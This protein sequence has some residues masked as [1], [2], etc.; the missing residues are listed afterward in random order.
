MNATKSAYFFRGT[1]WSIQ[2]MLPVLPPHAVTV[3]LWSSIFLTD[4][5]GMPPF[6]LGYE[7]SA[8]PDGPADQ[9]ISMGILNGWD[10]RPPDRFIIGQWGTL[11]STVWDYTPTGGSYSD[12]AVRLYWFPITLCPGETRTVSTYYG[13]G[14]ELR[15]GR[16]SLIIEPT[17]IVNCTFTPNP[18]NALLLF[19]NSTGMPITDVTAEIILPDGLSLASGSR[20][21]SL[22][23]GALASGGVGTSNWN[24][25][26][27]YYPE[28][29]TIYFRVNSPDLDSASW[30]SY[31]LGLPELGLAPA[32]EVIAPTAGT[33]SACVDQNLDIRLRIENGLVRESLRF[34]VNSDT[35]WFPA[36][37]RLSIH[38]DTLTYSPSTPFVCGESYVWG[39]V[40][41]TDSAGCELIAPVWGAFLYDIEPPFAHDEYP[42]DGAILGTTDLEELSLSI[43]DLVRDVDPLSLSLDVNGIV[44]PHDHPALTWDGERLHFNFEIAGVPTEDGDTFCVS[45]LTASDLMPDYCE[46]NRMARPYNWCFRINI[47]DLW[48]PDTFAY[49]NDTVYIYMGVE[50]LTNMHVTDFD[51]R[52]RYFPSVM[53][54][55]GVHNIGVTMPWSPLLW[56]T[57]GGVLRVRGTGTELSGGGNL[58]KIIAVIRPEAAGGYSPLEF[59]SAVFNDGALSSQPVDGFMTILWSDFNFVGQLRFK[60]KSN[61]RQTILA[62]GASSS[63]TNLYDA[64]LDLSILP[65]V[66]SDVIAWFDLEDPLYP[67]I[68]RLR[69]D[70]RYYGDY[71]IIWTGHSEYGSE[72]ETTVVSWQPEYLPAGLFTLSYDSPLGLVTLNMHRV[73]TFSFTGSVDFTIRYDHPEIVRQ[74]ITTCTGWNMLS[75]PVA[76]GS[77]LTIRD[78]FPSALTDAFYYDPFA[79]TYRT[80]TIPEPG[81]GFWIYLDSGSTVEFAGSQLSSIEKSIERGW[82]LLG[83]PM[84]SGT[85]MTITTNPDGAFI[86]SSIFGYDA[87]ATR[88]YFPAGGIYETGRAYFFLSRE[89]GTV[90]LEN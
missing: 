88:T 11:Y 7:S 57:T 79:R 51:I 67:H 65:P 20:I 90:R 81:Q 77:S 52:V 24:I 62:F 1:L 19:N 47:I 75:L 2:T 13:L 54:I 6:W 22:T 14:K 76:I 21:Q 66:P 18:F 68:N 72:A 70:I 33:V 34:F 61:D 41:A 12:S 44:Y 53:N 37:G 43:T 3:A 55:I 58:L 83:T 29:D 28:N 82:N 45:L 46:P 40:E 63:A 9:L 5:L 48:L 23:P 64:G 49:I 42:S 4:T 85:T 36:S 39:V 31:S 74:S 78:I 8:G 69:R 38:G 17:A 89:R 16:I 27:D 30:A 32:G 86:E 60:A 56:E 25:R 87:C 15:I 35:M 80:T 84:L 71:P 73:N 26:I 50:N 59:V 10:A